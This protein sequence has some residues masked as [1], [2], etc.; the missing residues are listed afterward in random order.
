MRYFISFR[1]FVLLFI[2]IV[3]F[4]Q[5]DSISFGSFYIDF[6]VSARAG[7]CNDGGVYVLRQIAMNSFHYYFIVCYIENLCTDLN[8]KSTFFRQ[9]IQFKLNSTFDSL[10]IV[11]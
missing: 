8:F 11:V 6:N 9:L 7:G 4:R 1:L 10:M 5:F 3:E 2:I